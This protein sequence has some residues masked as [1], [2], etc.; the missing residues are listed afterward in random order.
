MPFWTEIIARTGARSLCEVG[1]NFGANL[2][3]VRICCPEANLLGVDVNAGAREQAKGLGFHVLSADCP[4][5]CE[6]YDLVFTAGMLIHVSPDDLETT[7]Q[8]II[9]TSRKYVLAIEY[10]SADEEEVT[11]RGE[12]GRLW[13]R[14]YGRMYEELGLHEVDSGYVKPEDGFDSCTWWLFSKS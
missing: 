10:E 14:P 9:D 13:K 11:Y 4:H 12:R 2:L 5:E 8:S 6:S 1:C 7:M 3:A